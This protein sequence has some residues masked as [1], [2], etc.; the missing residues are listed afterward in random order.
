MIQ[1]GEMRTRL[2]F[3]E[4]VWRR[5]RMSL[6]DHRTEHMAV[7]RGAV[8]K[9]DVGQ[10]LLVRDLFLPDANR[11]YCFQG[12]AGVSMKSEAVARVLQGIS[13]YPVL[14][15]MHNHVGSKPS[16]S[17]TDDAGAV[18]QYE[19][20]QDFRPGGILV[21]LVFGPDGTYQGRWTNPECYPDWRLVEEIRV[22]GSNGIHMY[23]PWNAPKRP[24]P[25]T[26]SDIRH[27]EKHRRIRPIIGEQSLSDVAR[28]RIGVVGAGGTGSAF[29]QIARF[30]FP[31]LLV[32][33]DDRV[34]QSNLGR[35]LLA[36]TED[37][38]KSRRKVDVSARELLRYDSRATVDV[39]AEKFPSTRAEAALKEC[40]VVV[41]AVDNV[42]TRYHLAEF[43]ARHYKLLIDMGSGVEMVD[44]RVTAMGS[45]VRFQIPDGPCLGCL[46]MSWSELELEPARSEKIRS[47]YLRETEENPGE[48]VTINVAAANLAVR[49]L[50]A[51][52][53][54]HLTR[55]VPTYLLYDELAPTI[56]DFTRSYRRREDCSICAANSTSIQGWGDE[57]PPRL[58][59]AN[60]PENAEDLPC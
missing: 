32:I 17:A 22:V 24:R 50:L 7:A 21:Q 54:G 51:Y 40:D 2:T 39:L 49:N 41:G 29:I 55:P 16:F 59:L 33:D 9:S 26:R 34:E 28:T 4:S 47:G 46:G 8:S 37:A 13:D 52:L 20:Y 48:V 5:I 14:I 15:D 25:S 53:G 57:L 18:V 38:E 56:H 43:A 58:R 42:L 11:D 60:P 12:P 36:V 10:D 3:A 23:V 45:Q 44:G 27:R 30:F 6:W 31:H 35:H 1:Q 19:L